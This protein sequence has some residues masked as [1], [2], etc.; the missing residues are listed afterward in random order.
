MQK[1]PWLAGEANASRPTVRGHGGSHCVIRPLLEKWTATKLVLACSLHTHVLAHTHTNT[2]TQ[3]HTHSTWPESLPYLISQ[4]PVYNQRPPVLYW[5]RLLTA[6]D[7]CLNPKGFICAAIWNSRHAPNS[8]MTSRFPFSP[9]E[10]RPGVY[11]GAKKE[12]ADLN[13]LLIA[14]KFSVFLGNKASWRIASVSG[15]F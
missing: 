15:G 14:L 4:S 2:H 8:Q 9:E 1:Y 11:S 7:V 5:W 13:T 6:N 12:S 10:T 3:T